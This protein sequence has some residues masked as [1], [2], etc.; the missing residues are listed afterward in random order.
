MVTSDHSPCSPD[1]KNE[2]FLASWGG[3]AGVQ[4][5]LPV[6]WTGAFARGFKLADVVRW[7][8]EGPAKLAGLSGDRGAIK[9]G[10]LAHLVVFDADSVGVAKQLIHRHGG[11]PYEG[12]PWK[13]VVE[14]TYL[15]G[16]RVF[17]GSSVLPDGQGRLVLSN[18]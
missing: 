4:M 10:N 11:S 12:R 14:A 15:H 9:V 2:S 13:G 1:L 16:K 5:L 18:R 8:A 6:T 17:D 3:I 7:L